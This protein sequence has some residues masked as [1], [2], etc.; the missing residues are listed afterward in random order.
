MTVHVMPGCIVLVAGDGRDNN[1][2]NKDNSAGN[3]TEQGKAALKATKKD[4]S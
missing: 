2:G 3:N 1:T 4:S